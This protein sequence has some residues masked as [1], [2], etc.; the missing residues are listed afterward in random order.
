MAQE[1]Y[2]QNPYAPRTEYARVPNHV[3]VSSPE[4]TPAVVDEAPAEAETDTEAV[5]TEELEVPTGSVSAILKWVGDDEERAA[6]ALKAEEAGQ[7]RSSLV[8]K[9]KA[10]LKAD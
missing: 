6:A 8:T 3:T 10:V 7:D 5:A 9:L 2:E 1:F 4:P